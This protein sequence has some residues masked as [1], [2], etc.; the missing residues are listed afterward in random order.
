MKYFIV[1]I[2]SILACNA[3]PSLINYQPTVYSSVL[4]A[5]SVVHLASG[6][7][8]TQYHSQDGLGSYSYGYGGGPSAKSEV[9]TLDGV[10]RG[11]YS[12][13]DANSK[14]QTVEY[15]SDALG[16]RVAAT[17]LPTP[18]VDNGVAPVDLAEP[19]KPVE[20]TV[21]VKQA[22]A[23]HLAAVAKA[24]S[25]SV[26]SNDLPEAPKP[27]EDTPEVQKAKEEHLQ[28]VEIAKARSSEAVVVDSQ[29]ENVVVAAAQPQ[30]IHAPLAIQ[31]A[32]IHLAASPIAVVRSH[33]P[34]FAYS[35]YAPGHQVI[36]G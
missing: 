13:V 7:V 20:D 21:E 33:P 3:A 6:P 10:T 2:S 22:R 11:S 16:F 32:A 12:Y 8:L 18:P 1:L 30:I 34:S 14:L 31:P 5:P 15:V 28:A 17:N 25:E 24:E 4:A 27:V 23:E 29:P 36:L 9:K 26:A 35:V 19:P